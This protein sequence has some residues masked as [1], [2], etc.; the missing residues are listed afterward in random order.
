MKKIWNTQVCTITITSCIA[1]AIALRLMG[2]PAWCSCGIKFMTLH[3]WSSETSQ[4]FFDPYSTSHM[5]HGMIF[6]AL[7]VVLFPAL[8][9]AHRLY[10]SLATE[11]AWELFENSTFIIERYRT[12]TAS[13]GYTG[14]S[15]LNSV[16]D[17]LFMVLGFTLAYKLPWKWTLSIILV[18]ELLM[19]FL[20]RDN[21]L[22][23][24]MMLVYPTDLLRNWQ[25]G[26]L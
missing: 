24:I 19:L 7:L 5:L 25:M 8:R 26:S 2:Q 17:V 4:H 3:A 9:I 10:I 22:L 1:L 16:S 13:L 12:A 23:N 21:L 18:T 11:I 20:Y 15:I 14:D 6:F